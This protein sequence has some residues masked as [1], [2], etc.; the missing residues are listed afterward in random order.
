MKS[1]EDT[2]HNLG[3]QRWHTYMSG[4]VNYGNSFADVADVYE[5]D[6]KIFD[7]MIFDKYEELREE[8]YS[9]HIEPK[10]R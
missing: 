10:Y 1:L 5:I 7:K 8:Y 3:V 9:T 2:I 4:S 6:R